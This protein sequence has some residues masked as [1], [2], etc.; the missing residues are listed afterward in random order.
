M[1]LQWAADERA[2]IQ[3]DISDLQARHALLNDEFNAAV[4]A[5]NWDKA[6]A[7]SSE[8]AKVSKAWQDKHTA[9]EAAFELENQLMNQPAEVAAEVE[10]PAAAEP[11]EVAAE[12]EPAAAEPAEVAAAKGKRV[13][14]DCCGR[15]VEGGSSHRSCQNMRARLSIASAQIMQVIPTSPL[16]NKIIKGRVISI[17]NRYLMTRVQIAADSAERPAPPCE[18]RKA[19]KAAEVDGRPSCLICLAPL[20]YGGKGR[21]PCYCGAACAELNQALTDFERLLSSAAFASRA[22]S[23]LIRAALFELINCCLAAPCAD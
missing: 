10:Q 4:A 3:Q 5:E 9:L 19:N 2:D 15:K 11:A 22:E 23:A 6:S 13:A 20:A 16:A 12:V 7:I 14:C 18:G 1:K 21:K 17:I 8:M